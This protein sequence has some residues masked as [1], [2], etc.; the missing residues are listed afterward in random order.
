MNDET[1]KSLLRQQI[2]NKRNNLTSVISELKNDVQEEIEGRR[3]A[4][5]QT[6]EWR[7]QVKKNPVI[8]CGVAIATG[9]FAGKQLSSAFAKKDSPKQNF[10]RDFTRPI[11]QVRQKNNALTGIT[12]LLMRETLKTAQGMIVP[13]IIGAISGK[14]TGDAI[15]EKVVEDAKTEAQVADDNVIN[16]DPSNIYGTDNL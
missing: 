2:E 4:L 11:K 9:Y 15:K 3:N 13:M 12:D 14:I 6:F 1:E 8:A 5:K 7:Y 16:D 10:V